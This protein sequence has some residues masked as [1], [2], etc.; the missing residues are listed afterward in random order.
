VAEQ[1]KSVRL[2]DVPIERRRVELREDEDPS[3]V[4]VQAIADRDVDEA[5]LPGD[6]NGRLRAKLGERKEPRP[7]AA[8]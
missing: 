3:Y 5:V 4:C 8:T 2:P 7:S 6:G 1:I